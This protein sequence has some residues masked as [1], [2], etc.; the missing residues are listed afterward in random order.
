MTREDMYHI[1]DNILMSLFEL[2]RMKAARDKLSE[3]CKLIKANPL[4]VQIVKSQYANAGLPTIIHQ[5]LLNWYIS[6]RSRP[7]R[8]LQSTY[9]ELY[10]L[11]YGDRISMEDLEEL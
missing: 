9:K 5:I 8:E 6:M 2:S 1:T 11:I 10:H 7:I 3:I 4:E